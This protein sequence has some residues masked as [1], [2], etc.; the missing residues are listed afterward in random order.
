MTTD[1][2]TPEVDEGESTEIDPATPDDVG[3]A[4]DDA[5]ELDRS[6]ILEERAADRTRSMYPRTWEQE[7]PDGMLD[8][9]GVDPEQAA[10]VVQEWREVA[11]DL[12]AVPGEARAFLSV[13]RENGAMGTVAQ[14]TI[15]QWETDAVAR[16]VEQH[17]ERQAARLLADAKKVVSRD[18]LLVR[19]M[20]INGLGSH[21]KVV[22]LMVNAA[23]RLRTAGKLK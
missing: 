20:N 17:G 2:L 10:I 4:D 23:Q 18:P 14:E 9:K 12:L 5:I 15:A 21:P 6:A 13:V 16:L 22:E 1:N 8:G 3:D 7:L 19:T 11:Q